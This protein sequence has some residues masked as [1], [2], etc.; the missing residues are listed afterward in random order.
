MLDRRDFLTRSVAGAAAVAAETIGPS[1][2]DDMPPEESARLAL[3]ATMDVMRRAGV[4]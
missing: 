2:P 1:I 4:L 3:A